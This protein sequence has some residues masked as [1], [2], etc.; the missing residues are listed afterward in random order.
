MRKIAVCADFGT[1]EYCSQIDRLAEELGFT[2]E[3]F[4]SRDES[5]KEQIASF[6]II[7]GYPPPEWL[8]E[9]KHLRWMSSAAAGIEKF[10]PEG[11]LPRP[12]CLLTN[13]SGI[14]GTTISEHL[15]MMLLMLMR[16][17]PEYQP[18]IEARQWKYLTPIRSI[19]GS[20][21]LLLGTGDIGSCTARKLRALGASVTGINRS[22]QSQ[23][24]A[25]EQILPLAELDHVLP[26]A[27]ALIMALPE[28]PETVGI[29]S[30]ER[31]SLL[32][33]SAYVINVGRGSAIDQAVLIEAL[34][35]H[36]LA[37]AALDVMKPEPLPS[38]HP[39][40]DCPNVILTPH[41]SGNMSLRLT[42]DLAVALF[43]RNLKI[44]HLADHWKIRSIGQRGIDFF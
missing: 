1:D 9:A 33:P 5:M 26:L 2:V 21:C 43:C 12:D 3:Y 27:D 6:E 44:T 41:I 25:F 29:L 35:A 22:G 39:L 30:R 10:L 13:G 16:R 11:V 17:M 42:C 24:P 19:A 28:T 37:G 31:I 23:E 7:F 18:L 34:Q 14:Y 8:H 20:H 4:S 40:W 38:D 36:R 15:L 32:P